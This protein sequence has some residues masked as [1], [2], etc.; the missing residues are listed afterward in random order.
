MPA[1]IAR[2]SGFRSFLSFFLDVSL[3]ITGENLAEVAM[4]GTLQMML[5]SGASSIRVRCRSCLVEQERDSSAVA[6]AV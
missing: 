1:A 4:D 5:E 3:R 2:F 6:Y